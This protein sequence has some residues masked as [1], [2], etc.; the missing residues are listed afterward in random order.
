MNA[1]TGSHAGLARTRRNV[2]WAERWILSGAD[3]A[4]EYRE[5]RNGAPSIEVHRRQP[6]AGRKASPGCD[7]LGGAD[8]YAD[9]SFGAGSELQRKYAAAESDPEVIW[10][11]LADWY[12]DRVAVDPLPP[13]DSYTSAGQM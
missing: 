11:E 6:Q 9:G 12:A 8:C 3:G 1:R 13:N 10:A 2:E 4:V 7:A 5:I